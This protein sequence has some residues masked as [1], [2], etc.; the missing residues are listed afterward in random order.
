MDMQ[1][2]LQLAPNRIAMEHDPSSNAGQT[3]EAFPAAQRRR[4]FDAPYGT[5]LILDLHDC[6]ASRFTRHHIE[7]Y[8][9][10]LCELIDMERCDLFF[11]DDVGV[12][13]EEQQSH[14]KTKGTS[15][16]Y[17]DQFDRYPQP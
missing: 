17:T 2:I 8:C 3:T 9:S 14:P 6:D 10:K 11:W 7:Q 1:A 13:E 5:E 16:V 4:Q 12:P 15:A